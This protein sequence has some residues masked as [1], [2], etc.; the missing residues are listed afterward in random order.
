MRHWFIASAAML[1]LL[2]FGF[3]VAAEDVPPAPLTP[4]REI[5]AP[6]VRELEAVADHMPREIIIQSTPAPFEIAPEIMEP[7]PPR[8]RF[9]FFRS[10]KPRLSR[11]PFIIDGTRY[12]P[13]LRDVRFLERDT[14]L[15]GRSMGNLDTIPA[16][17]P[18]SP[19]GYYLLRDK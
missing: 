17:P 1:G 19:E 5:P 14:L 7:Q 16:F 2:R 3:S 11:H 4:P 12:E 9:S 8:K 13:A 6:V 10:R 15:P 18:R